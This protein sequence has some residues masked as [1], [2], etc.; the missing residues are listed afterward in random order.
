MFFWILSL[1]VSESLREP[2]EDH[3]M[4]SHY[5]FLAHANWPEGMPFSREEASGHERKDDAESSFDDEE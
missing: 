1:G 3:Q 4:A 2:N 5:Q